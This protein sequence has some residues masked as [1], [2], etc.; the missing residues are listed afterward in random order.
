MYILAFPIVDGCMSDGGVF[1]IPLN[2]DRILSDFEKTKRVTRK[3]Q[4]VSLTWH[5]QKQ[6]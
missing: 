2:W 1:S 3:I 6:S 5:L 4:L